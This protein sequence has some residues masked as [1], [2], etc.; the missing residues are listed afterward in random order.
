[1]PRLPRKTP[2]EERVTAHVGNKG[3]E[4]YYNAGEKA[5]AAITMSP[6]TKSERDRVERMFVRYQELR[7]VSEM[8]PSEGPS[9][10]DCTAFMNVLADAGNGLLDERITKRYFLK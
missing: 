10:E 4:H 8:W 7:G 2:L 1:M 5:V 6:A 9:I 3:V